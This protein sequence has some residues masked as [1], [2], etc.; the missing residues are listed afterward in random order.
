MELRAG[1]Q[2]RK[3]RERRGTQRPPEVRGGSVAGSGG[4]GPQAPRL[5]PI[6][7]PGC[8]LQGRERGLLPEK[9][10]SRTRGVYFSE[11]K[12]IRLGVL[13][14]GGGTSHPILCGSSLLPLLLNSPPVRPELERRLECLGGRG[15]ASA[16]FLC[17]ERAPAGPL[18]GSAGSSCSC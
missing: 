14:G 8:A 17:W 10:Y 11:T 2:P 7:S 13:E 4:G 6:P 18:S 5:S 15:E 16:G 9:E 3:S 12:W 1:W